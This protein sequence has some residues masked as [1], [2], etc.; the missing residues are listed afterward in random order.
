MILAMRWQG[1]WV[2]SCLIHVAIVLLAGRGWIDSLPIRQPVEQYLS[3]EL[4]SDYSAQYQEESYV[5]PT[6]EMPGA[7]QM[8][9]TGFSSHH[10]PVSMAASTVEEGHAIPSGRPAGVFGEASTG[11]KI[12]GQRK[13]EGTFSAAGEGNAAHA[14]PSGNVAQTSVTGNEDLLNLFLTEIE[15]HKVY[16]YNARRRGQEGNVLLMVRLDAGGELAG[17]QVVQSSGITALDEAAVALV[18]RICPFPR[19][20]GHPVALKVPITYQLQD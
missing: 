18:R 14:V 2:L 12:N 5:S 15:K 13:Q 10:A 17:L 4:L 7:G 11:G 6:E 16:P 3:V 8:V 20:N 1:A 9:E 19:A